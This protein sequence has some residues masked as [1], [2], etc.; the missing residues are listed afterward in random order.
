LKERETFQIL[1]IPT[2]E[3]PDVDTCAGSGWQADNALKFA[4]GARELFLLG[5]KRPESNGLQLDRAG[6]V[7]NVEHD[8]TG[9][10]GELFADF[11][12]SSRAGSPVQFVSAKDAVAKI[13]GDSLS[14]IA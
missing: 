2:R 9:G 7:P 13:F 5:I 8:H 11:G 10:L 3:I 12:S 4:C 6:N 14:A 1:T